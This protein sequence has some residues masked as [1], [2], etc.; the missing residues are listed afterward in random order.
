MGTL[1]VVLVVAAIVW[2]VILNHRNSEV[3]MEGVEFEA[4]EAPPVVMSA[5]RAL[6]VA[7]GK[8]KVKSLVTGVTV[9]PSGADRFKVATKLDDFGEIVVL[10][11]AGGSRVR[12]RT[13]E[14]YV[15]THPKTHIRSGWM[16]ASARILHGVFKLLSIAPSAAKMKKLQLQL[17]GRVA[18]QLGREVETSAV[19][20][21][22]TPKAT[23]SPTTTTAIARRPSPHPAASS[24]SSASDKLL[25]TATVTATAAPSPPPPPPV[26]A[27]RPVDW[28][29]DPTQRY[30]YR[31]WDGQRS[32]SHVSRG[33]STEIDT[34]PPPSGRANANPAPTEPASSRGDR[35]QE[36]LSLYR[37]GD[38]PGAEA[39][40]RAALASGDASQL[41][42]AGLLLV[43]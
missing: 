42:I 16:G 26:A 3:A 15:G 37:S 35:I 41:P 19:T 32:T 27:T 4:P 36:A 14:L 23:L 9:T 24:A 11:F 38:V 30:D 13:T 5:I 31:Y 33:A 25:A 8:A 7:G 18:R 28:Y 21:P 39:A 20:R 29:P 6:Y 22:A 12:A 2:G 1:L 40:V 43:S 10:P 17:E 34:L